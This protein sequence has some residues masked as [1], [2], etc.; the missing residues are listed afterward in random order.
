[1]RARVN[2]YDGR[3]VQASRDS[4]R[5]AAE[6]A[7]WNAPPSIQQMATDLPGAGSWPITGASFIL[8]GKTAEQGANTH[9]VLKFFA[10][11][12]LQG[13]PMERT[14]DYVAIPPAVVEQLPAL[15]ETIRDSAGKPV[16]P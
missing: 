6:A 1:M 13:E 16:W 5:A 2:P 8:V 15:W 14:L 3:F 10:W 7:S 4:F 9:A 11:A 12:L